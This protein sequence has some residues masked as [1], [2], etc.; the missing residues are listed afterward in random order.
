MTGEKVIK[1]MKPLPIL[2]IFLT[3]IFLF[4]MLFLSM[5]IFSFP[6]MLLSILFLAASESLLGLVS[7][8]L[9]IFVGAIVL[10]WIL[11]TVSYGKYQYWITN[12]RVI[13]KR[14]ILGYT[15][16]SIPYERVSDVIV[17][18][19]FFER[20]FGFGSVHVQSLAGQITHHG[21]LGAEGSM[22]AVAD[23]EGTQQKIFDLMKKKRKAEHLTM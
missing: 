4:P 18:R 9:M 11:A 12:K 15:I 22:L 23:P 19:T 8:P 10:A 13:C 6:G 2:K 14:G 21:R 3:I 16:S 5:F 17:S 7:G 1:K 20:L